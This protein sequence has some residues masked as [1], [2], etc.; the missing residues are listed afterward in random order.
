MN[1]LSNHEELLSRA[2]EGHFESLHTLTEYFN[3]LEAEQKDEEVEKMMKRTKEELVRQP[4]NSHVIYFL[5]YL[6]QVE[7]NFPMSITLYEQAIELKHSQS[8][9]NLAL[10]YY[11]GDGVRKDINKA[12]SLLREAVALNNRSAMFNLAVVLSKGLAGEKDKELEEATKLFYLAHQHKHPNALS[13]LESL[14][15]RKY[16]RA[17]FYLILIYLTDN[18]NLPNFSKAKALFQENPERILELLYDE[19]LRQLDTYP[20]DLTQLQSLLNFIN[21]NDTREYCCEK[22]KLIE[23][24]LLIANGNNQ[25]ALDFYETNLFLNIEWKITPENFFVLGSEKHAQSSGFSEQG[26]KIHCLT[27]A[28]EL[29]HKG[30]KLEKED[31][32]TGN[33]QLLVQTLRTI[34]SI[35]E[36]KTIDSVKILNDKTNKEDETLI[37]AFEESINYKKR[38]RET[39][40]V[41]IS[42]FIASINVINLDQSFG[43]I[44]LAKNILSLLDSGLTLEEL[45]KE[46]KINTKLSQQPSLFSCIH[47][48]IGSNPT[49]NVRANKR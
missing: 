5:A 28:C 17:Q 22:V 39:Q 44:E 4:N 31:S 32:Y 24:K 23:L 41:F 3:S 25:G 15:D 27:K 29:F 13:E 40:S 2:L 30:Y 36:N 38:K 26:E 34:Q 35:K 20:V 19:V 8:M 49:T 6:Y 46:E 10:F 14:A 1:P 11:Y 48:C 9:A 33:Y 42:G 16:P 47:D 18:V 7:E 45:T 12:M 43:T 21:E 37:K